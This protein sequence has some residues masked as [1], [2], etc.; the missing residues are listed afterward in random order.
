ME[1]PLLVLRFQNKEVNICPQ[2]MPILIHKP[3]ELVEKI[4]GLGSWSGP[5]NH[6]H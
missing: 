1:R 4:P 6:D 2:C 5:A 3:E